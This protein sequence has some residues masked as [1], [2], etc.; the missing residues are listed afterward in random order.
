VAE[1]K[2]PNVREH[3]GASYSDELFLFSAESP[4]SDRWTP[5]PRNPVVSDARKAR[6]AGR[7]LEQEGKLFRVSQNCSRGYGYGMNIHEIVTLDEKEYEE[8]D[9][10]SLE[11]KWDPAVT[12]MHT[13]SHAGGLTVID[14]KFRRRRFL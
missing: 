9:I 7:V 1:G 10:Q 11:P 6:P 3:P 8:R 2:A 14:A 13:L 4:L 5:H 12:A